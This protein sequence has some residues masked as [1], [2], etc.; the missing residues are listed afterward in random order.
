M[1][2]PISIS[3]IINASIGSIIALLL[4]IAGIAL[5]GTSR[6][7]ESLNFLR[8]E[9]GDIRGGMNQAVK[10]LSDID[11]QM[12]A[13][14]KSE[15]S[16]IKLRELEQQLQEG[17]K[18]SADINSA[19]QSLSQTS[20]QQRDNLQTLETSTTTLVE[21]LKL[22]ASHMQQLMRDS[23]EIERR[24]LHAYLSYFEYVNGANESIAVAKEDAQIAFRKLSSI[25]KVLHKVEAPRE[26]R[27]LAISMKKSIRAYRKL[28]TKLGKTTDPTE[29]ADLHLKVVAAGRA[30][31]DMSSQLQASVWQLADTKSSQASATANSTEEAV[32]EASNASKKA[33]QVLQHSLSLVGNSN[34][35]MIGLTAELS[36]ALTELGQSFASIPTVSSN[37]SH[38]VE[39]M[40]SHVSN[41]DISRLNEAEDKAKIAEK[42]AKV[43]PWILFMVS[44]LAVALSGLLMLVVH[45]HFVT[46]LSHFVS[47]V[48]RIA[49]NDLRETVP[50]KGAMGELRDVIRGLNN[51]ITA[52]R[53]SVEDMRNAGTEISHNAEYFDRSS[54]QSRESLENQKNEIQ[55]IASATE[56]LDSAT[57]DM[58]KS[59]ESAAEATHSA[60]E[61]VGNGQ[62]TVAESQAVTSLLSE[63][64]DTAYDAICSLKSDSDN[65]GAV[66]DVIRGIAEQTNLLALNAAIEAARA[67]ESGR[68]FAVVADEV[69]NLARNTGESIAEI[70]TLIQRLQS[71]TEHG[72]SAIEEGRKQVELNVQAAASADEALTRI[73]QAVETIDRTNRL[74]VSSTQQQQGT[75]NA[76]NSNISKIHT[77]A[78]E[79]ADAARQHVEASSKLTETAGN[80]GKI[81]DRFSL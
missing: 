73:T 27:K 21:Q 39:M 31:Q 58:V 6:M 75:V 67:G 78:E 44:A 30:L 14:S 46:P 49:N 81:V 17:A 65:I 5:F 24:T 23:Q 61:A 63:K 12:Q 69:R 29:R 8:S 79:T 32:S 76:I 33:G 42:N 38:S 25:T 28:F 51:L 56:K 10:T 60:N 11:Q 55:T 66:L 40:K 20:D 37:V 62:Q 77:L 34:K 7:G 26:T 15:D 71:S 70:E 13:L 35:K 54:R 9:S 57:Q 36:S 64:V 41:S 22:F 47:G 16:L 1:K 50:E 2:R 53:S 80:L 18:A 3:L 72:A 4:L 74:I 68:G 48:K 52:L 59:V 19:L 43:I 45:R